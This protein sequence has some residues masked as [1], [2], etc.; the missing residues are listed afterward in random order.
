MSTCFSSATSA[1]VSTTE[2]ASAITSAAAAGAKS[3]FSVTN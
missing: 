1:I 3:S 2:T